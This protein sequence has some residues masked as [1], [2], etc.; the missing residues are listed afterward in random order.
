MTFKHV[1]L[2]IA[3]AAFTACCAHASTVADYTSSVQFLNGSTVVFSGEC[4]A[5]FGL[6]GANATTATT[7]IDCAGFGPLT[8]TISL[9]G[10]GKHTVSTAAGSTEPAYVMWENHTATRVSFGRGRSVI[11]TAPK[12]GES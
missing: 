4:P 2:S 9:T 11:F 10:D 6:D 12:E 5:H 8:V 3:G 7:E 1:L